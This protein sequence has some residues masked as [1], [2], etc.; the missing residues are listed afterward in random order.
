MPGWRQTTASPAGSSVRRNTHS[1]GT[2]TRI[3]PII[4][5]YPFLAQLFIAAAREVAS[6]LVEQWPKIARKRRDRLGH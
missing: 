4:T 2:S 1:Q 5:S 3:P 6:Q